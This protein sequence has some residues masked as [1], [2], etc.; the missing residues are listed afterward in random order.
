MLY[1][2]LAPAVHRSSRTR[3]PSIHGHTDLLPR[4]PLD[5]AD[6]SIHR[7]G[8][9]RESLSPLRHGLPRCILPLSTAPSAAVADDAAAAADAF[10]RLSISAKFK[11]LHRADDIRYRH[12]RL[13]RTV[14]FLT[15]RIWS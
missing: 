10:I 15:V 9:L 1:I 7:R 8:R 3:S 4:R 13:A 12:T 5:T 2:D 11:G 14:L 6:R